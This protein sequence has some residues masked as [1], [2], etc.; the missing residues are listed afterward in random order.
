MYTRIARTHTHVIKNANGKNVSLFLS[1]AR[2]HTCE[3]THTRIG[4]EDSLPNARDRENR[5]SFVLIFP[6]ISNCIEIM[7]N[8][9]AN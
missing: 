4:A 6:E 8:K 2:I 5:Y 9:S 1:Y 3:Y 7:T